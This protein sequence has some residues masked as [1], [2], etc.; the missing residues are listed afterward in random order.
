MT[1]IPV[2]ETDRLVIRPLTLDDVPAVF[3]ACRDPRLT[4]HTLFET[5]RTP[6][7]TVG[8]V[9]DFALP[10]YA[11]GIPEPLGIAWKHAPDWVIGCTGGRPTPTSDGAYEIGYWIAVPEWGKGVAT[12]AVGGLIRFLFADTSTHR[13][14]A[15]TYPANAAS[16]R[17]LTKL[18]FRYEGTLRQVVFRRGRHHDTKLFSLLRSDRPPSTHPSSS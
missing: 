6:D 10:R 5:H 14:Q 13:L 18:G 7:D 9:R 15:C 3:E 1:A 8:F 16:E 17:V 2:L 12:E 11:D 4:E